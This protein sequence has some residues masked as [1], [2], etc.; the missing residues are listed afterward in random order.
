MYPEISKIANPTVIGLFNVTRCGAALTIARS[1]FMI[2][3]C[4]KETLLTAFVSLC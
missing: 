2:S 3:L 1:L 4:L